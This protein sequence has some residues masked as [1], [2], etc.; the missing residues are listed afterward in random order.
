MKHIN[1]EVYRWINLFYLSV[2]P[3]TI[4]CI[5]RLHFTFN[6]KCVTAWHIL[7]NRKVHHKA[8]QC[9]CWQH[10]AGTYHA[11]RPLEEQAS[12][13]YTRHNFTLYCTP[14]I[15][16]CPSYIHSSTHPRNHASRLVVTC[17]YFISIQC[18]QSFV[19]PVLQLL[20]ISLFL[21]AHP[22]WSRLDS[23]NSSWNHYCNMR[24]Y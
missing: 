17:L 22:S 20:S 5:F 24:T 16:P 2:F 21:G 12:S 18:F 3:P 7:E 8:E 23:G 1:S 4:N 14:K 6:H 15:P 10:I 11:E 9:Q 13:R 19:F